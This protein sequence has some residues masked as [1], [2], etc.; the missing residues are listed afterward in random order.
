MDRDFSPHTEASDIEIDGSLLDIRDEDV[1]PR[2][3]ADQ[4]PHVPSVT[5]GELQQSDVIELIPESP[6]CTLQ[7]VSSM[8]K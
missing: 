2:K 4:V 1:L 6:T 3:Q 5:T 7:T 8:G